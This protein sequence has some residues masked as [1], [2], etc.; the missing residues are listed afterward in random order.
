LNDDFFGNSIQD[1]DI[2]REQ[3]ISVARWLVEAV[4][5]LVLVDGK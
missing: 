3:K 2:L 5:K 4:G 1:T